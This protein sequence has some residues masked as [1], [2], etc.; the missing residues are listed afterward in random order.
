MAPNIPQK[1]NTLMRPC[2]RAATHFIIPI[3]WQY[4]ISRPFHLPSQ[5][6][7]KLAFTSFAQLACFL[8]IVLS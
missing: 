8:Q 2:R 5:Q 6:H 3:A 4:H 7:L 1:K